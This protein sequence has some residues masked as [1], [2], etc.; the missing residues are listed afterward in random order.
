MFIERIDKTAIHGASDDRLAVP[1]AKGW[2]VG[3]AQRG[4]DVVLVALH[5]D[6]PNNDRAG[7]RYDLVKDALRAIQML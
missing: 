4:E 7:L 5:L 2:W 1:P 3:F 6:R